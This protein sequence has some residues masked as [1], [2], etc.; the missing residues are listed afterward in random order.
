MFK[1]DYPSSDQWEYKGFQLHYHYYKSDSLKDP[2]GILFYLHGLNAHGES[3]GYT[4]IGAA[5][6][7]GMD[8]YALDFMN[9]GRSEGPFRG[10]ITSLNELVEQAEGFIDFVMSKYKNSNQI[11]KYVSGLSLGGA[12]CFKMCLRKPDS[13]SGV[14]F[15]SPALR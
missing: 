15:F 12:I 11:K 14:I 1:I 8:V 13:Y 3:S 5:E 10:E 2:K 7:L 4:M 6:K 9:F